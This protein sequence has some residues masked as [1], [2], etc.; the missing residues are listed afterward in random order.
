LLFVKITFALLPNKFKSIA[1]YISLFIY[2]ILIFGLAGIL[3]QQNFQIEG[4]FFFI[5]AGVF[6][7][8]IVHFINAKIIGP[9]LNGRNWC[10]WGCWTAMILDLLPYKKNTKR[11]DGFINYIKYIYFALSLAAIAVL[12]YIFKYTIHN[13]SPTPEYQGSISAF[14]WF[15]VGNIFYYI[16]GI[17]L[18]II[19]KDN[20]AFCK[21]I[22]PASLMLKISSSFSLLKIK[23]KKDKCTGCNQCVEVCRM[24]INIPQYVKSGERV[25]S[26]ECILCLHCV[27]ECPNAVLS[28]T[29]GFDVSTKNKIS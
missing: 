8:V 25:K 20:R 27:G 9:I 21:Y 24:N 19:M 11:K 17:A 23:G 14:Y 28:A 3:G 18:A 16:I 15:A 7:G 22:C 13:P 26:N 1:R 6:G 12:V 29:I 4:F 10:G 5:L 2:G